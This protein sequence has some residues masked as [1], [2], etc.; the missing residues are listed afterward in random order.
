MSYSPP[1]VGYKSILNFVAYSGP[2]RGGWIFIVVGVVATGL[3]ATEI[4]L[5]RRQLKK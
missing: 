5:D 4:W 2:D 3:L 1:I